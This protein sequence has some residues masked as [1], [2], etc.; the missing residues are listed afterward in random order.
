MTSSEDHP[1]GMIRVRRSG[2]WFGSR[3]PVFEFMFPIHFRTI[4]AAYVPPIR[5][6]NW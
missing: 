4:S 2:Y 6:T 1:R 5:Y 3:N